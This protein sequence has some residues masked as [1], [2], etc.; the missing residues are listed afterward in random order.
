[1]STR[2]T[3]LSASILAALLSV[4]SAWAAD[5]GTAPQ[6][7]QQTSNKKA[8]DKDVQNL[9]AV[10][11]TGIRASEAGSLALKKDSVVHVDV[12]TAEDIGKL[13]AKNVADTLQRLPGV[14]ISSSSASEGGF[15]ENDRVSLRGTNP[16]LTQTLINGHNVGTGDW[17]VLSQVQTVGRSVSYTLLPSE[18][19]SQVVIKK[20]AT[21]KDVE[22][23]T[24]GTVDIITRKPLEFAKPV[25]AEVAVGGVYS[26]LPKETK[27][28]VSGL[29]NWKNDADTFGVLVQGFYEER[30][31][32]REGQEVV[33]GFQ[34]IAADSP[35]AQAHPDLAGVRYPDL[36][37]SVLFN[38]TRKR[39]GGVIDLQIKPS[40]DFWLDLN[41]FYS[42]LEA[43]NYNRNYMMWG[44]HG[45]VAAGAGLQDGYTVKNG[46]LTSATWD[47]V[48]GSN[49]AYGVYD[50]ISRPGAG[51]ETS[52]VALEAN[53]NATDH[54]TF[55]GQAGT[56]RGKGNSPVQD[57][58]ELGTAVGAGASW[59]MN[60]LDP[61][62]WNLG[63]DNTTPSG[64][65][66][67]SGWIFGEGN[68]HVKDNEDW[69]KVDGSL[70]FDEG[71]LTSLDFG[72]RYADHT[73][74]NL[75]SM[76]QGPK[77]D[78]QN[79]ANYPT[80][81]SNYPSNFCSNLDIQCP[82]G[83][84][85]YSPEQLAAFNAQFANRD[86]QARFYFNDIYSV[87]EKSSAVY[88]QLNFAGDNW[89]ANVGARYVGTKESIS[90][91][92]TSP[93]EAIVEGP[94]TG[95]AF[96]DYYWN[97]YKHDYAQWLPS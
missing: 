15:D 84:W 77:G 89:Q 92:S 51:S 67:S 12:V 57:V 64:I 72:V 62:D 86:P 88:G 96:G 2:K 93:Q 42:K 71:A 79:L 41:A 24:A 61:I 39:T 19:V 23:G 55:N 47:A 6:T 66:P 59:N 46:V 49:T 21:A 94:I 60:G 70:A 90:Y 85:Y 82:D 17:F 68:L 40:N 97:T 74:E 32:Q 34:T 27:P 36:L 81:W 35:V 31:L 13:P 5:S 11:V 16:S 48:P 56:T 26:S 7:D 9:A 53:W 58:I 29:F 43:D 63:G 44:S 80:S 76:A 30:S 52:Y 18:I 54:L 73:R 22:G 14:N 33:N 95:S 50:Q 1:M 25:T 69:L 37:G 45:F 87:N 38:Q 91:S 20:T 4:G 78:W 10:T 65:Q 28:Q 3:L 8:G 83:V 75:A